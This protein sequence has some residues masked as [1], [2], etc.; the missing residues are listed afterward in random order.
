MI[1]KVIYGNANHDSNHP[2][3]ELVRNDRFFIID[4]DFGG[5]WCDSG[6]DVMLECLK[7]GCF[8][9]H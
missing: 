8:R 7:K 5:L 1:T 9:G 6:F 3:S 2:L 4:N